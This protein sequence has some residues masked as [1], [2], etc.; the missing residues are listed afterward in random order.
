APL[1]RRQERV[2]ERVAYLL[3]PLRRRELWSVITLVVRRICKCPYEGRATPA[4]AFLRHRVERFLGS[5]HRV[6]RVPAGLSH[7]L[8][9]LPRPFGD[10][11]EVISLH[12]EVD[13]VHGLLLTIVVSLV[14]RA[15]WPTPDF[16]R[17]SAVV[18]QH[19]AVLTRYVDLYGDPVAVAGHR[20]NDA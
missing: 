5:F 18:V 2:D 1:L 4:R 8:P 17:I 3:R 9:R 15:V 16:D 10:V 11:P 7:L 20:R 6:Q 14:L 19:R 13:A 12:G